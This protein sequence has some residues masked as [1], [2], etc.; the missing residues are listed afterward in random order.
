M[1]CGQTGPIVVPHVDERNPTLVVADGEAAMFTDVAD[2]LVAAIQLGERCE[3]GVAV[4]SAIGGAGERRC[5][6]FFIKARTLRSTTTSSRSRAS[7]SAT[8]M[9]GMSFAF[10]SFLGSAV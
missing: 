6:A 2:A 5:R 9:Q 1:I 7:S 4:H 3:R 8:V 10:G